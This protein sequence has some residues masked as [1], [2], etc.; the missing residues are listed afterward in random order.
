MDGYIIGFVR[1]KRDQWLVNR[2]D[3]NKDSV[4]YFLECLRGLSRKPLT[5]KLLVNDFGIKSSI[6]KSCVNIL[7][8]KLLECKSQ[9]VDILFKDWKRV[10]SQV[11]GYKLGSDIKELSKPYKIENPDIPSLL[12]SIHTYYAILIKLLAAEISVIYGDSL[13]QSYLEKLSPLPSEKLKVELDDLE[14]GGVFDLLGIKNFLER[15][16]FSWYLNIWDEEI[17]SNIRELINILRSYEP[18]TAK[19]EP[20]EIKDLFK[21]LYQYLVPKKMRHDLGEYF[22]PDWLAE[23]V[24]DEVK[25]DGDLDK[26]LLDPAC[27]SGTFIVSIIKRIKERANDLPISKD[28]IIESIL[29]NV[30]GFDLNPLAVITAR[31]NYL[32]TL[33]EL[34]SFRKGDITIPVYLCDSIVTPVERVTYRGEKAYLIK[35][36]V[37]SFDIPKSIV[38]KG[39]IDQI[40][41]KMDFYIDNKYKPTK[42]TSAIANEFG[43]IEGKELLNE[44]YTQVLKLEEEDRNKIWCGLIKNSFAPIF[45]GKFD[46]V[47]GN[48]S[49]INWESLPEAYRNDSKRLWQKYGL[50]TLKGYKAMLGGGKKDISMLFTYIS[51]DKYLTDGGILGFVITQT[52]FKTEA[53]E[54]FR[55][56]KFGGGKSLSFLKVLNVHDLVELKPFE[57]SNMT[58]VI[59]LKK[60]EKTEYPVP[61][62]FW[63]K[64]EKG[65]I[66]TDLTYL[67][68]EEKTERIDMLAEPINKRKENSQWFTAPPELLRLK[69]MTRKSKYTAHA[70][71]Y[72]GGTN[73]V[74]WLKILQRLPDGDLHIENLYDVGKKEIEKVPARIEPKFVYPLIK[75]RNIRKWH[76]I[77]DYT[78]SL[79]MQDPIKRIGFNEEKLKIEY[80]KIYSYLNNFK[81]ILLERAAYK[82]Y[83]DKKSAPFYTMFN[84]SKYTFYPY[85]VVWNRMGSKLNAVVV[86]SVNDED[87]GEKVIVPEN[88]LVFVPFDTENEAHYLCAIMNSSIVNFLVQAYSVKGSKS[89]GTPSILNFLNIKKFNSKDTVHLKLSELSKEAH[90]LAQIGGDLTEV[91]NQIDLLVDEFYRSSQ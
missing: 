26:R 53:G 24:L 88:V 4:L 73:G 21:K 60:G 2:Y 91:E 61:Y 87:I 23:F 81:E 56:F 45:A 22:T 64:K 32:I 18:A 37:G 48:P 62:T 38:D 52:V 5:P 50:F 55:R 7:Y 84:I 75:S 54:G 29:K 36:S 57:A 85:K 16:Y 59:T 40:L 1:Y 51:A 67:E 47:V 3:V 42:F 6:S 34:I 83:F 25:Y 31:A 39:M 8:K 71:A 11:C 63:K 17:E 41:D 12:F 9:R 68:V 19:L 14:K 35:S 27:G 65:G 66:S 58:A 80:S 76:L 77:G 86:S 28:K 10:F 30:V 90:R 15:D 46:Y 72:S 82:K 70:G 20:D 89:F 69:D 43:E 33:G 79:M 78:Y 13:L 49:W 44:L 74:Y